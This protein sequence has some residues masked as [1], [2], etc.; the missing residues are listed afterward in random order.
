MAVVEEYVKSSSK[1]VV[2]PKARLRRKVVR[3]AAGVERRV[4]AF[5]GGKEGLLQTRQGAE[6]RRPWMLQPISTVLCE[7]C[8]WVD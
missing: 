1:D 6:K 2:P 4:G 8:R 3:A 7:C 5:A